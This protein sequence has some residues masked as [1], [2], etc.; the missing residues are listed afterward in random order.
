MALQLRGK[1]RRQSHYED[2]ES[3]FKAD[4]QGFCVVPAGGDG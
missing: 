2:M 4:Y 3:A 1:Y